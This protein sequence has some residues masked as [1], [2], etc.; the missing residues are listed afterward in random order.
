MKNI[1]I[2]MDRKEAHIVILENDD[3]KME[4]VV[5]KIEDYRPVGGSRSKTRWG[6]QDVVQDSKYTERRKHQMKKYFEDLAAR[7]G[8]AGAIAIYGPAA[9]GQKFG[10]YLEKNHRLLRGRVRCIEKADSM[11]ENQVRALIRD[12]FTSIDRD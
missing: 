12:F 3:E 11:T 6:P 5:S 8:D 9:V 2:W 4:T 7:I 10:E 1:G